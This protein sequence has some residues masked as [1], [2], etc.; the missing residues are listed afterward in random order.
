M[1]YELWTNKARNGK[2]NELN[3]EFFSKHILFLKDIIGKIE[4]QKECCGLRSGDRRQTC[5]LKS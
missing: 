3:I 2:N 5:S 1:K 4:K